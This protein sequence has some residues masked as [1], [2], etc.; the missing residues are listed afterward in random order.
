MRNYFAASVLL[1]TALMLVTP[2]VRAQSKACDA[3]AGAQ[4]EVAQAVLSSQH[5]YDCCDDTIAKCLQKRPVCRLVERLADAICRQAAAGKSRADIERE[6]E[7]RAASTMGSKH[8][9]DL[10]NAVVAGDPQA[11]VTIVAYTCARCPYCARLIPSLHQ[12]VTTGRLKGKAK[13]YV[14]P[15]P[16]RSHQHSTLGAMA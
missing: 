16:I 15:F 14:K 12:S 1:V 2:Q 5:P 4:R 9:I 7:R 8:A 6:L 3:L 11:K 10:G 13:L